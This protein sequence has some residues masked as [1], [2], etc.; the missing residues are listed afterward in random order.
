MTKPVVLDPRAEQEAAEAYAWYQERSSDA[1]EKFQVEVDR[2]MATIQERSSSFPGYLEGTRRCLLKK[3]PYLIV[4][5][6]Y[7]DHI[8]VVA[9]AHGRRE[10][11]YWRRRLR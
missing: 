11:G 1:A 7:P 3:F 5:Q 8:F 4:F 9:V 2:A 10:P 6:E